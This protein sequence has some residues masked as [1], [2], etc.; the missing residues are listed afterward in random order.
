V[1]KKIKLVKT[2]TAAQIL[3]I[4]PG[5]LYNWRSA[6]SKNSP[7]YVKIGSNIYYDVKDLLTYIESH[8][9]DPEKTVEE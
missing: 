1:S 8:K 6:S 4:K 5:T 3:G 2:S 9:I 7:K